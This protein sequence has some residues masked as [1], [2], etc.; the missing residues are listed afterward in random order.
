MRKSS[1]WRFGN[2]NRLGAT[3]REVA[4]SRASGNPEDVVLRL[5]CQDD[6]EKCTDHYAAL[7]G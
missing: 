6:V 5:S 2:L 4:I 1:G 3:S 7:V